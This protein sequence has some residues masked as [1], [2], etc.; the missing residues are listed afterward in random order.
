MKVIHLRPIVMIDSIVVVYGLSGMT[1]VHTV[2]R[3][4]LLKR[5]WLMDI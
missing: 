4:G 2:A 1:D 5:D 3:R